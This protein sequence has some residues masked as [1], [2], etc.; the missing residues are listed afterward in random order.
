MLQ[1]LNEINLLPYVGPMSRLQFV[2]VD[3]DH[4]GKPFVFVSDAGTKAIIVC[5][6]DHHKVERVEL[7]EH[8]INEFQPRDVLY[9]VLIRKANGRNLIY[10]TYR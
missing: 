8:V 3:F 1:K 2:I 9:V 10:F 4:D 5:D 6:V 7:P